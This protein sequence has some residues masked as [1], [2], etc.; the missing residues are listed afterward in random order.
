MRNAGLCATGQAD[1]QD[2]HLAPSNCLCF[3]VI[4]KLYCHA[5]NLT[6]S[7]LELLCAGS[8]CNGVDFVLSVSVEMFC[9]LCRPACRLPKPSE[10]C[11]VQSAESCQGGSLC[12]LIT[13]LHLR[14]AAAAPGSSAQEQIF[15][16]ARSSGGVLEQQRRPRCPSGL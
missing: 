4:V 10:G 6:A 7:S 14:P 5:W 12:W 8:G 15:S 16:P 3:I 11:M 1:T 2:M 13:E 9:L